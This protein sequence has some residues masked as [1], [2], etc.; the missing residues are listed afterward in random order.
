M[1]ILPT[2]GTGVLTIQPD[3]ELIYEQDGLIRGQLI[4][5][6]DASLAPIVPPL[7]SAH[8][9]EPDALC[10]QR[11]IKYGKLKTILATL[12]YIGLSA[13]PTTY[14]VEFNGALN[15]EP[16]ETHPQFVSVLGGT[17]GAPLNSASFDPTTGLFLGFPPNAGDNLGGEEAYLVP[18]VNLRRSYWSY[19]VP[20]PSSMGTIFGVPED[21]ILPPNCKNLLWG[22][23]TYRQ[24]GKLFQSAQELL[25]SG[26]LGWNPVVYNGNT[27]ALIG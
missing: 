19:Q 3:S 5:K 18:G 9:L 2:G 27:G 1:N 25:G 15:R 10:F 22:P 4:L 7:W 24:V 12:D 8:P 20:N 17:Q 16:I 13:D 14:I 21:I 26:P 23:M 11:R 6:G